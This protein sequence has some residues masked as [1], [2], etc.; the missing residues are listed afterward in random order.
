M[1][2]IPCTAQLTGIGSSIMCHSVKRTLAMLTMAC[3]DTTHPGRV[4][5]IWKEGTAGTVGGPGTP[6]EGGSVEFTREG[7][8]KEDGGTGANSIEM[9]TYWSIV[10]AGEAMTG[11]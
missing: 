8:P 11:Q 6:A 4:W 9:P 5:S 1:Q 10:G 2:N 7:L 3:P